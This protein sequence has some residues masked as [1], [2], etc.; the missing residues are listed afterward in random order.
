MAAL[1][2][3][4]NGLRPISEIKESLLKGRKFSQFFLREG[5]YF[6][7]EPLKGQKDVSDRRLGT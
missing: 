4:F 6:H 2:R 5:F 3:N 1:I 7:R